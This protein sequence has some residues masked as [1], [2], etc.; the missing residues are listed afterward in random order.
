MVNINSKIFSI[1]YWL[2]QGV[3]ILDKLPEGWK[4]VNSPLSY[5]P[6]GYAWATNCKSRFTED[7]D[8][9]LIKLNNHKKNQ[10]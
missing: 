6:D 3:K 7:F 4:I 8:H 2:N 1:E 10:F 9:A 5:V